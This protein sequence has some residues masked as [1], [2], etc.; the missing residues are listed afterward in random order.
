MNQASKRMS[1]DDKKTTA[2]FHPPAHSVEVAGET[3]WSWDGTLWRHN[4]QIATPP[5]GSRLQG[6]SGTPMEGCRFDW[7]LRAW[8][9]ANG[10][11]L[12]RRQRM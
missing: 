10:V 12:T 4:N 3:D 1:T 6:K 5:V 2:L 9:D 8:L 11:R 7:E